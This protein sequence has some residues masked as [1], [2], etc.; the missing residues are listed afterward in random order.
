MK[1]LLT[2]DV[3]QWNPTVF[4][5]P[6]LGFVARSLLCLPRLSGLGR[7]W[8]EVLIQILQQEEQDF[9]SFWTEEPPHL[10]ASYAPR[11]RRHHALIWRACRRKNAN[12][13]AHSL[14]P[15][16]CSGFI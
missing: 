9:F 3:K 13:E 6:S 2:T 14:E 4:A 10:I 5:I 7:V 12:F 11:M 15:Q 1:Q 8:C 16:G